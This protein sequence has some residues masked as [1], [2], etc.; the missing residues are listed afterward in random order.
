[1]IS[2]GVG[3]GTIL[4]TGY[5]EAHSDN[6]PAGIGSVASILA[7]SA[8]QSTVKP[9]N[10]TRSSASK[11]AP[12]GNL[13]AHE[14]LDDIASMPAP[15]TVISNEPTYNPHSEHSDGDEDDHHQEG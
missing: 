8:G 7:S 12:G 1:M 15:E 2:A 13:S 6:K 3:S 11:L 10:G 4:N 9:I 14:S 5:S